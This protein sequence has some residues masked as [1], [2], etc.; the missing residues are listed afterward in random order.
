MAEKAAQQSPHSQLGVPDREWLTF[1]AEHKARVPQLEGSPEHLRSIME[2]L[3]IEATAKAPP[4]K[5]LTTEDVK[6][7][8]SDGYEVPVR[9]YTPEGVNLPRPGFV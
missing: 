4:I 1:Y 2:K 5:N 3:K 8:A 7:K 6:V 9:V